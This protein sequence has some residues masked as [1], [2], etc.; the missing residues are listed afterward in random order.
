MSRSE[1]G[2]CCDQGI[3]VSAR[4][5]V[6]SHGHNC[7]EKKLNKDLN[8]NEVRV[9][10]E[11]KGRKKRLNEQMGTKVKIKMPGWVGSGGLGLK[12]YSK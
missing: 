6:M 10:L 5:C 9:S 12:V 3:K 8:I 2:P 11:K 7:I 4:L 1:R